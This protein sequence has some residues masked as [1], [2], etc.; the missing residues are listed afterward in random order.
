MTSAETFHPKKRICEK[1]LERRGGLDGFTFVQFLQ[2]PD[3]DGIA[4]ARNDRF[5]GGARSTHGRD[6]RGTIRHSVAADG[7]LVGNEWL[8]VV[9]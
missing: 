7:L 3:A 2:I 1:G 9:V 6:A 8:P 4:A 5:G